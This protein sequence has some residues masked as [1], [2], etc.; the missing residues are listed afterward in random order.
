LHLVTIVKLGV[1]R[2][3]GKKDKR[4]GKPEQEFPGQKLQ[5]TGHKNAI[6]QYAN[7]TKKDHKSLVLFRNCL[8]SAI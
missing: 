3:T 1:R 7:L 6:S 4:Q 8:A 5:V 2:H